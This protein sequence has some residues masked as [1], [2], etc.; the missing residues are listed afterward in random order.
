MF[1]LLGAVGCGFRVPAADDAGAIDAPPCG[2]LTIVLRDFNAS[3]P[4]FEGALGDDRGLVRETL[5]ADGKPVYAP[6]GPT[7]TVSG[8]ASFDQWYRDVAGVNL[9]V[10]QAFPLA[11]DPSGTFTFDDQDFFPLDG[12]G[13]DEQTAGHNFHFT[14]EIHATF[15]Y[16]G[17]ERFQFDGDDDVWVFVNGRLAVDLG[18]V[19]GAEA[20]MIDF[21]AQATTLGL[22]PGQAYAFDVFHA[23][24]HTVASTFRM[25]TTIGCFMIP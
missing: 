19:H 15:L 10:E 24:R 8:Q 1:L 25:V 22:T 3:H 4:D 2:E 12:L 16:R 14:S 23:E 7:P 5:G 11:E 17:G 18:G 6:A 20:A 9:R 13:F 21:D